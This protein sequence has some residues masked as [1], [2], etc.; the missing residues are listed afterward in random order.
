MNCQGADGC[1]ERAA[2]TV[3]IPT[4]YRRV[5]VCRGCYDRADDK[6]YILRVIQWIRQPKEVKI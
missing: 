3:E 5:T 4:H 1:E 2:V 6:N